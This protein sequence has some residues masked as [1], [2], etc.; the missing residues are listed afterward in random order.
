MAAALD[1][2]PKAARR[3][4][5]VAR[6]APSSADPVSLRAGDPVTVGHRDS[7]WPEYLWC[8]GPDGRQGWVHERFLQLPCV[9]VE[10]GGA[11]GVTLAAR[12]YDAAELDVRVGDG[13]YVLEEAG[14]WF[15]VERDDGS[16]G[17]LPVECVAPVKTT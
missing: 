11:A 3:A 15:Y 6:H 5:V 4:W 7:R 10:T 2:D 9:P 1:G 17:W 12:D 13:L 16:R 14:G 8:T